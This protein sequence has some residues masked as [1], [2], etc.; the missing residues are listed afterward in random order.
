[1]DTY[2]CT[3]TLGLLN[4]DFKVRA[5]SLKEAR[6]KAEQYVENNLPEGD[7]RLLVERD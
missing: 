2:K 3:Y 1:M 5:K 7:S 6:R 4:A